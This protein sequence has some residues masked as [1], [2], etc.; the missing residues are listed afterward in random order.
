M[1]RR[2]K[3]VAYD[4]EKARRREKRQVICNLYPAGMLEWMNKQVEEVVG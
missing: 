1:W 4:I 3:P 2:E